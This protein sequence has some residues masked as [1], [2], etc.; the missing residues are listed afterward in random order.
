MKK[1][2]A[3][4]LLISLF[5]CSKDD[6]SETI[7]EP[8]DTSIV[9]RLEDENGLTFSDLDTDFFDNGVDVQI[10]DQNDWDDFILNSQTQEEQD[11]NLSIASQI[12]KVDASGTSVIVLD[13]PGL[14]SDS[15]TET[16]YINVVT[17]ISGDVTN[18]FI[19]VT[20]NEGDIKEVTLAAA[21]DFTIF[22]N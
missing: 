3:L 2:I 11:Y 7:Q 13:I 21:L 4:F 18:N 5:A 14:F 16:I 17:S 6:D 8:V 12:G 22:E 15:T 19:A 20:L 10:Y 1:F 9:L